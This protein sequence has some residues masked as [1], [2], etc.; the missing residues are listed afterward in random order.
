M[1]K[2]RFLT[3]VFILETQKFHSYN[4]VTEMDDKQALDFQKRELVDI[5]K[6]EVKPE[7]K[8]TVKKATNKKETP[9]KEE[10]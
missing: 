4:S 2:V 10:K 3:D 9:K 6:E 7:K 8:E 1:K 5:L